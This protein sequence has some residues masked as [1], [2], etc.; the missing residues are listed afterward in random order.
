SSVVLFGIAALSG[1]A[2][3]SVDLSLDDGTIEPA[4]AAWL[5]ATFSDAPDGVWLNLDAAGLSGNAFVSKW[6]FHLDPAIDPNDLTFDLPGTPG[7]PTVSAGMDA[8]QAAGEGFFDLLVSF[9][10]ANAE[11]FGPGASIGILIHHPDRGFSASSFLGS[12]EPG[13]EGGTFD[14]VAHVQGGNQ[15]GWFEV[16]PTVQVSGASSSPSLN[17][18]IEA[19]EPASLAAWALLTGVASVVVFSRRRLRKPTGR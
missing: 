8:F 12:S 10:Q 19:P 6:Y 9:P 4:G 5:T 1:G 14:S 18:A 15:G 2:H 3:G 13:S 7:D 11:R 16:S 17:A